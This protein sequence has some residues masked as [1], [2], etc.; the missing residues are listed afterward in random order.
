MKHRYGGTKGNTQGD[1][2]LKIPATMAPIYD[3]S[4][5]P[6]NRF[7]LL[8][9]L[10]IIFRSPSKHITFPRARTANPAGKITGGPLGLISRF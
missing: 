5:P 8:N 2:K 7:P 3:I 4:N 9:G 1:R 6:M 10:Y